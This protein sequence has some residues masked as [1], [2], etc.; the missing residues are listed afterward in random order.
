MTD[1]QFDLNIHNYSLHE[2]E[3]IIELHR[4][5]NFNLI[6]IEALKLKNKIFKI[7]GLTRERKL[8]IHIFIKDIIDR[9]ERHHI[10]KNVDKLMCQ[11]S[12]I[13]DKLNLILSKLNN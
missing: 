5:Y 3:D 2:L 6:Q 12:K 9:L 7:H 11:Q 13:D 1:L 4:P 8:E 10:S